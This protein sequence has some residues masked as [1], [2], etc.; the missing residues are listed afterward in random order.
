MLGE[1]NNVHIV[2]GSRYP[3]A[4]CPVDMPTDK[5]VALRDLLRAGTGGLAGVAEKIERSQKLAS[6][7]R[8]AFPT[9]VKPHLVSADVHDDRLVIV[10]DHAVWAAR[11]RYYTSDALQI[12]ATSHNLRLG[13]AV[14]RV[15][16]PVANA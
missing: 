7:V 3:P 14:V 16:P 15:R 6:I 10:A 2:C 1:N 4:S 12:I 11:M 8:D 13:E 9:D 5:P